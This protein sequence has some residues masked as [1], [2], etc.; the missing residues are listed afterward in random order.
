M[1]VVPLSVYGRGDVVAVLDVRGAS[2]GVDLVVCDPE[3][4]LVRRNGRILRI[5]NNGRLVFFEGLNPEIGLQLD[6]HKKIIVEGVRLI[7]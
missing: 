6:S 2:D 3:T 5:T 7:Q 1:K 4:R